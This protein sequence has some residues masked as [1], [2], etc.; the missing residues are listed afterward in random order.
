MIVFPAWLNHLVHPFFGDGERI[1]IAFNIVTTEIPTA[2][3][4]A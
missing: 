2:E 3:Q 4:L 1:S